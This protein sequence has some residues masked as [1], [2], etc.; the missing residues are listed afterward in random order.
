LGN[1]TITKNIFSLK[2]DPGSGG[3]QDAQRL[4]ERL[5][6][7]VVF[8]VTIPDG[9]PSSSEVRGKQAVIDHLTK[10]GGIAIFRQGKPQEYFVNGDRIVVIGKDSF[11]ITEIGVTARSEYAMVLDYRDGL[12]TR[13]LIIQDLSAFV[14]AYRPTPTLT[15][16]RLLKGSHREVLSSDDNRPR[17]RCS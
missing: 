14:D 5:A 7:D 4:I 15:P 17:C 8:K 3:P 1:V 2:Q 13:W 16:M 10:L 11:E 12:I 6:D 9:T